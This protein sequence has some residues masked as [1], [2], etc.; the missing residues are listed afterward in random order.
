MAVDG[1][2]ARRASARRLVGP[3]AVG[4]RVA[5]PRAAAR[6]RMRARALLRLP[7][8]R[9]SSARRTSAPWPFAAL[10]AAEVLRRRPDETSRPRPARGDAV[11]RHRA[12]GRRPAGPG[13][14]PACATRNGVVAEALIVGRRRPARAGASLDRG[15]RLLSSCS[16]IETRDGHLSVTPVGGRGPATPARASTSSRSRSPRS[17]TPAP[18]R[19]GSPATRAGWRGSGW[20]G[21]GSSATTTAVRRCSTRRTGGGYDGLQA[22]GPNLN[23]GAESTLAMLST[24]QHARAHAASCGE[25]CRAAARHGGRAASRSGP[26]RRPAVPARRGTAPHPLPGR[27]DRRPRDGPGRRRGRAARGAAA[28]RL[29]D[30]ATA[31]TSSC[32]PATRRS[33]RRTSEPVRRC[34]AA[35]TVLLGATFTAEYA[36]EGA[37]LCNPSAVLHPDQTGAGRGPGPGRDQRARHRRRAP[38]LDRLPL[39]HR[40]ARA[41][42]WT[43]EPRR[44]TRSVAGVATPA[45]WRRTTCGPC[46]PTTVTLDELAAGRRC[47]PLPDAFDG[48]DLDRGARRSSITTCCPG[49][50]RPRPP[51]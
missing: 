4:P 27:R 20:R 44:P 42:Q 13:P 39:G 37:A 49:P 3:G 15:L 12:D 18:A 31:T 28:R 14:S 17:P 23:Q 41:A 5:P 40:R 43:F 16:S 10:G 48:H 11:T 47:A 22:D 38:L 29:R 33:S 24:A 50:A 30:R 8:R 21:T 2:V 9:P 7:R 45:P 32:W 26:G 19:T 51:S 34:R 6:P 36:V 35:R 25:R 46:S 1:A